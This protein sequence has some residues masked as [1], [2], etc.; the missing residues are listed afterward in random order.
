M[1]I[2][3]FVK[4][5]TG[6]ELTEQNWQSEAEKQISNEE[7]NISFDK[8]LNSYQSPNKNNNSRFIYDTDGFTATVRQTRIPLFDESDMSIKDAVFLIK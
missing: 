6:K 7:Y 3:Q 1:G 8:Y 5:S 4:E 2:C